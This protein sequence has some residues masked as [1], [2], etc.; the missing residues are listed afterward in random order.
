MASLFVFWLLLLGALAIGWQAGDRHDRRVIIAIGAA[1]A[2]TTSAHLVL[3]ELLAYAAV[4]L[5]D[6]VLLAVVVRYALTSARYWPIWFAGFHAAAF[7]FD[8]AALLAPRGLELTMAMMSGFW[9]MPALGAMALGLLADRG[10]A[11]R[12]TR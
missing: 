8:L 11:D 10:D 9:A 2:L 7:V 1:A 4:V 3:P 5:I 12:A 6:A